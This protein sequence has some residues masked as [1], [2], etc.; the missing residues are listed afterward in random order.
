MILT[1][2]TWQ[3]REPLLNSVIVVSWWKTSVLQLGTSLR[4]STLQESNR[5]DPNNILNSKPISLTQEVSSPIT[6]GEI[7]NMR[8]ALV[9]ITM[10]QPSFTWLELWR[11][12]PTPN[13]WSPFGFIKH[14]TISQMRNSILKIISLYLTHAIP[15]HHCALI[16][17]KHHPLHH[18]YID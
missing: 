11:I 5:T 13:S 3:P 1:K 7:L 6:S 4:N 10:F 15:L 2:P 17:I 18:H 16:S 8:N 9:R 14:S 12:I